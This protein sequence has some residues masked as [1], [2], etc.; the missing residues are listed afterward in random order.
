MVGK[1]VDKM[2]ILD[3]KHSIKDRAIRAGQWA[4]TTLSLT[5]AGVQANMNTSSSQSQPSPPPPSQ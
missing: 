5:A 2:P 4:Y 3:R 1:I